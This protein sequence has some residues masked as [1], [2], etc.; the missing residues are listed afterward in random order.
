MFWVSLGETCITGLWVGLW[1]FVLLFVR[2][3]FW[4]FYD[5]FAFLVQEEEIICG[6]RSHSIYLPKI[7]DILSPHIRSVILQM[8]LHFLLSSSH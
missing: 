1:G 4:I 2:W 5:T 3:I 7:L 6:A 8:T